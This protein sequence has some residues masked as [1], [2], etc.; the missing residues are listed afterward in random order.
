M[1]PG[2]ALTPVLFDLGGLPHTV[3]ARLVAWSS[4]GRG[5]VAGVAQKDADVFL[6]AI[7]AEF[8]EDG[9]HLRE[10]EG[11]GARGLEVEIDGRGAVEGDEFPGEGEEISGGA[12]VL[13]TLALDGGGVGEEGWCLPVS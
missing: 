6:V 1:W 13:A 8:L 9:D 11:V 2:P 4:G 12:D 7:E 10:G 5:H 3:A